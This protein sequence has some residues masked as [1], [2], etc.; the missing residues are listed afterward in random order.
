MCQL[1]KLIG[2]LATLALWLA[3][4]PQNMEGLGLGPVCNK[5]WFRYELTSGFS[6]IHQRTIYCD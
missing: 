3:H 1:Q 6:S 4:W 5:D 2:Y